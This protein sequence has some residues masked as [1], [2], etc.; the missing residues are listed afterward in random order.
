MPKTIEVILLAVIP[1]LWGLSIHTVFELLRA[2]SHRR[3]AQSD[4]SE[5]DAE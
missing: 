1:V 3:S 5:G 2:R 4:P